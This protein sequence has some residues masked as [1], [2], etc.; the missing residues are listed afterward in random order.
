MCILTATNTLEQRDVDMLLLAV[1]SADVELV[2]ETYKT[3]SDRS[4]YRYVQ[5][6]NTVG[7][8]G[9]QRFGDTARILHIAVDPKSQRKGYGQRIVKALREE[10]GLVTLVAE[11]DSDA[12]GF[13]MAVGF[14]IESPREKYPGVERFE[15]THQIRA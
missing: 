3:H 7:I 11:T 13:Y 5:S 4:L 10:L 12:I 8:C 2:L 1:G 9:I 6:G 14:K 15:C